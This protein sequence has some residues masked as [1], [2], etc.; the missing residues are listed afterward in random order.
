MPEGRNGSLSR[1]RRAVKQMVAHF[2]RRRVR[3]PFP[4]MMNGGTQDG[5]PL[6]SSL[7]AMQI[8]RKAA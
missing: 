8:G 5:V 4:I 2:H 1:K 7:A 6:E 3:V